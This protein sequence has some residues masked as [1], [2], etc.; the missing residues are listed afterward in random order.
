MPV[1]LTE[2]G[3]PNV[4]LVNKGRRGCMTSWLKGSGKQILESLREWTSEDLVVVCL[5]VYSL[6]E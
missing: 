3:G 2:F 5:N 1:T 6:R 4:M